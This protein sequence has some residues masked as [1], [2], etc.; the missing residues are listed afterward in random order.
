[1][2]GLRL[3][4]R[5]EPRVG[6]LGRQQPVRDHAVDAVAEQRQVRV[7]ALRLGDH[8]ALGVDDEAHARALRIREQLADAGE[9]SVEARQ[10]IGIGFDA[11]GVRHFGF[12]LKERGGRVKKTL[13]PRIRRMQSLR[14][15]NV[16]AGF[17]LLQFLYFT[18]AIGWCPVAQDFEVEAV[19][20]A[21]KRK[22]GNENALRGDLPGHHYGAGG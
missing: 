1:M 19:L 12:F 7:R 10:R 22:I 5:V 15:L 8:H 16:F 2:L 9:P 20:I 3:L 6:D 4:P 11:L 13:F 17:E 21:C 14:G 18:L